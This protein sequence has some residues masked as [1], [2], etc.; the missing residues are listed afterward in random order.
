MSSDSSGE[1]FVIARADGASANDAGPSSG[2]PSLP[3]DTAAAPSPTGA[4]AQVA[5]PCSMGQFAVVLAGIMA[6]PLA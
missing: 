6:L 5:M 3:S 4:A 1:I 2:L